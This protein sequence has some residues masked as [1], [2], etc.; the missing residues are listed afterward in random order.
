[1]ILQ[2][3]T[4]VHHDTQYATYLLSSADKSTR[5][6]LLAAQRKESG[7]WISAPPMSSLG[8]RMDNDTIRVAVGLCLGTQLCTP[9]QC[10]QCRSW[11][12]SFSIHGLHCG[13]SA[14]RHPQHA[15]INDLVRSKNFLHSRCIY[16]PFWSH[17]DF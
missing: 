15:A 3:L 16:L 14:G 9:H 6:Q 12:D 2:I 10:V 11:V 13:R 5:G 4:H 17:L 1:M 7:T 8:L